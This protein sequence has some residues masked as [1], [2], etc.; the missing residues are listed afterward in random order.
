[1]RITGAGKE[2]NFFTDIIQF[3]MQKHGWSAYANT[4]AHFTDL[5]KAKHPP[6]GRNMSWMNFAK[7]IRRAIDIMS[8]YISKV[9][10]CRKDL[11]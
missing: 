10:Q 8:V 11:F 6:V 3:Q 7:K 2:R 4:S 9:K 1:M 5:S